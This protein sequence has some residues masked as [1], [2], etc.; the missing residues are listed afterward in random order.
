M[1]PRRWAYTIE[2]THRPVDPGSLAAPPP[3]M[4]EPA[5]PTGNRNKTLLVV[6]AVLSVL[7]TAIMGLAILLTLG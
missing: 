1:E 2:S 3:V 7:V 6:L 5:A 4:L